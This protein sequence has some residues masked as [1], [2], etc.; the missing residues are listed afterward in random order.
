MSEYKYDFVGS[1]LRPAYLRKARAAFNNGTLSYEDLKQQED[2]AIRDLVAKEIDAGYHVVTDGEFRRATWHLDFIWNFNG[3]E[4]VT[5]RGNDTFNGEVALIDS[6]HLNGKVS[7][8]HHPFVDHFK[9]VKALCPEGV[10]A[11][12]TMPAPGQFYAIFTGQEE[13]ENTKKYYP[14]LAEL[15]KDIADSYVKVINELYEAGC[16]IVQFDDCTWG[17]FVNPQIATGLTGLTLE[18]LPAYMDTLV[19]LNNAVIDRAPKDLTINTHI[20]RGNYHST[21]FSSG[22][23]DAVA[24]YVFAKEHVD[25]FYLEF[26]DERSGGFEPLKY[27]PKD[28]NVVLGLITTKTPFL[29]DENRIKDRL[30]KASAYKDLDHLSLSPQCGFASCEIGNKLSEAQQWKKLELVKHIAEDVWA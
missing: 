30:K 11:K 22:A 12:Q 17:G 18:E 21:Y 19:N 26:D 7:V 23:Y 9:F 29:E 10:Q 2:N 1:F 20:C 25:T 15:R 14:D 5:E 28:K 16:R 4:H 13:I 6:V 8:S 27:V 3:V 24:P